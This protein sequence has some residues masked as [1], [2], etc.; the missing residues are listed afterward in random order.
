MADCVILNLLSFWSVNIWISLKRLVSYCDSLSPNLY[1]RAYV[2]NHFDILPTLFHIISFTA[3]LDN[4]TQSFSKRQVFFIT[5]SQLPF[6]LYVTHFSQY[7]HVLLTISVP[8]L[9]GYI[10]FVSHNVSGLFRFSIPISHL[11]PASPWPLPTIYISHLLTHYVCFLPSPL[12]YTSLPLSLS[13]SRNL[14]LKLFL[15]L[16]LTVSY[17]TLCV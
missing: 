11:H 2:S 10:L 13:I 9:L 8:Y 1:V 7:S 12:S 16:C 3:S 6:L 17:L 14:C 15:W 4:T 5:G